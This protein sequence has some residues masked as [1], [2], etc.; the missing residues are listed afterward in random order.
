MSQQRLKR[1]HPPGSKGSAMP[2]PQLLLQ[3]RAL[4][5]RAEEIR[6]RAETF[7]NADVREKMREVAARYGA[8]VTPTAIRGTSH[9]V[10]V[11]AVP[12]SRTGGK[13]TMGCPVTAGAGLSRKSPAGQ[14]GASHSGRVM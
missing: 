2:D 13:R 4:R 11:G 1:L 7:R 3:T 9:R 12:T 14:G 5:A 8:P 10:S 6:T